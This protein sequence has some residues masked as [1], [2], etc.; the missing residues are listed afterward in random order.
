MGPLYYSYLASQ[1]K[2]G[3]YSYIIWLREVEE[4][5]K[6]NVI[7]GIGSIPIRRMQEFPILFLA[8]P[9]MGVNEL[10]ENDREL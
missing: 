8:E 4:G 7:E 10:K 5:K 6:Q 9:A 1:I 2:K 3:I